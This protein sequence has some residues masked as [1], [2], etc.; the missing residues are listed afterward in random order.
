MQDELERIKAL[1]L[2]EQ[3]LREEEQRLREEEQRLREEEQRLREEEQRARQG[4]ERRYEEAQRAQEG[5]QR[6]QEEERRKRKEAEDAAASALNQNLVDFLKGCH[7]LSTKLIAVTDVTTATTGSTT[8]PVHRL[9]P[10]RILPWPDFSA[11]QHNFWS[12]LRDS[13]SMWNERAYPSATIIDYVEKLID[14]IGSEDDLRYLERLTLENMAR[15]IFERM[16]NNDETKEILGYIGDV[17]FE[18]QPSF[19]ADEIN[20]LGRTIE[21]LSIDTVSY[22]H[23]TL[24]TKRIV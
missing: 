15:N 14:P 8:N 12:T 18:N 16:S 5:A 19:R 22:T 11:R 13:N 1:L 17:S 10:K 9:F 3:Q 21:G 24:P 20:A 6:A 23:L 4:A 7:K 2:R